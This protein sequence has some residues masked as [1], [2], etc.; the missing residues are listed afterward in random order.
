MPFYP[1]VLKKVVNKLKFRFSIGR[2]GNDDTG[3]DRFLY[4]GTMKQDNGGY[5]LG[6]SDTGGMG[7]IGNGITE[8]RFEAPYLHGKLRK[9]RITVLISGYSTTVLICKLTIS[10]ISVKAFCCSVIQCPM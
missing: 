4:R 9:R 1:E 7:G 5:D 8:A 2:T 3:G 6:F 10:I